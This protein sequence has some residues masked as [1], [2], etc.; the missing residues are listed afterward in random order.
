ML[1]SSATSCG[2][3]RSDIEVRPQEGADQR[4]DVRD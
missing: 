2:L 4:V 3:D 1:A